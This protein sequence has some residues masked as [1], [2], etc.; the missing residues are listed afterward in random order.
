MGVLLFADDKIFQKDTAENNLFNLLVK[1]IPLVGVQT[2]EDTQKVVNSVSS[3]DAL[4]LDWDFNPNKVF[5][6]TDDSEELVQAPEKDETLEFLLGNSF[7]SLVYVFSEETIDGTE[8]GDKLKEKYGDR[9]QF[10]KKDDF[11]GQEVNYKDKILIDI[12]EWQTG[13][14]ALSLP[15][16]WSQSINQGTQAVFGDLSEANP[17][18]INEI[19]KTVKKDGMD[20]GVFVIDLLQMIL[21]EQLTSDYELVDLIDKT[22]SKVNEEIEV[23]EKETTAEATLA[24]GSEAEGKDTKKEISQLGKSLSKLYSRLYYTLIGNTTPIMTGDVCD[25]GDGNLGIIISPECDIYSI[26]KNDGLF[27][28]LSFCP[29][30]FDVILKEISGNYESEN[31]ESLGKSKK[32]KFRS[33]WNQRESKYH[34]LPSLPSDDFNRKA[35]INFSSNSF[36]IKYSE[37]SD[38]ERQYKLNS[39]FIQQLRQRY[40]A[41]IGRVG[42]PALPISVKDWNLR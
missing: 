36:K 11:E 40:L 27:D 14:E 2:I 42:V 28:I 31:Y 41:Y 24:I 22:C 6:T 10:V 17:L 26:R 4:I 8:N 15:I 35:I 19:Y 30:N 21:G 34:L 1:E 29:D 13:N 37:L 18:W 9:I 16:K 25:L 3:F 32:E 7:Y 23:L 5:A 39:P 33:Y 20:P 12:A 38:F